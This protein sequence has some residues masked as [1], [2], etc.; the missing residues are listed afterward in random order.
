MSAADSEQQRKLQRGLV[1]A[2][3][4]DP[5]AAE[6]FL[7]QHP[8]AV[9]AVDGTGETALHY[10]AVENHLA[11]VTFLADRG[12]DVNA[13]AGMGSTPLH[14]AAQLD[15]ANMVR[16]LLARGA[17]PNAADDN[18]DRPLH[19]ACQS[20]G[21][22]V[23]AALIAGGAD[24]HV[25]NTLEQTPLHEAANWCK[26]AAAEALLAAG[27]DVEATSY[28]DTPALCAKFGKWASTIEMLDLL[29][30]YGARLDLRDD[31]GR[32]LVHLAADRGDVPLLRHLIGK[33]LDPRVVDDFGQTPYDAAIS[34]EQLAAAEFLLRCGPGG[35]PPPRPPT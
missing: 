28:G 27:A 33:G 9:R 23:V 24:V 1:D 5:A 29:E 31:A 10:L 26:L 12:A 32:T 20:G 13:P 8:T 18:G 6:R 11:G 17:D 21:G 34:G 4:A 15:Y 35:S 25:R 19:A 14:H 3:W 16:L 22:D 2:C 30:R 7:A